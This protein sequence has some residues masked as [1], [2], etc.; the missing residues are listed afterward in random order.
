MKMMSWLYCTVGYVI[1][2]LTCAS[3]GVCDD[4]S[5]ASVRTVLEARPASVRVKVV[6][7]AR[8]ASVR[9]RVI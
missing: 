1:L 8:P 4:V 9:I 5:K 3:V 6:L 2:S 7:E